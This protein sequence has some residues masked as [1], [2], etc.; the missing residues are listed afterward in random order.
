M[1][2]EQRTK[3][4]SKLLADDY[5]QKILAST[6]AS[7]MSAQRLSKICQ[8]PIAACYRR[9]HELESVGLLGV[10]K[11]KEVYKGRKVRLYRCKLRSASIRFMNGRFVVRYDTQPEEEN[12]GEIPPVIPVPEQNP[13]G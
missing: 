3:E 13:A 10:D 12:G 4:V 6:Y 1:T 11:E 2:P 9:I 8:I 5:S 7:P